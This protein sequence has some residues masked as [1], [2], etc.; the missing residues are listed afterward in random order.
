MTRVKTFK[1]GA[2]LLAIAATVGV[3][4]TANAASGAKTS[5]TIKAQQGGF[6]GQVKSSTEKCAN[7]RTVTLYRVS[8]NKSSKVGTD[9]AQP[10]GD[11]FMWS[12]NVS[13]GGKYYAKAAATSGCAAGQ[14]K[15][16][17]AE[18]QG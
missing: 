1:T 5:V 18:A 4:A 6:F 9:V 13:K 17:S 2:A 7:G 16:V 15:T 11:G 14:S 12:I 10:N 8:G 3:T